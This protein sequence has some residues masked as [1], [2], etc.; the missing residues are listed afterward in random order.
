MLVTRQKLSFR[1]I[2]RRSTMKS[3]SSDMAFIPYYYTVHARRSCAVLA[4]P[5]RR[6][7]AAAGSAMCDRGDALL[8]I[9]LVAVFAFLPF[10]LE[11]RAEN[12]AQGR[13]GIR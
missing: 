11:R 8:C 1:R 3:A 9:V 5:L 12:V 4:P 7:C 2:R 13:A 10:A 6:S